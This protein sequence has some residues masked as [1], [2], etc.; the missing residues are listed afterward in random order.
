MDTC[1]QESHSLPDEDINSDLASGPESP[2]LKSD[3]ELPSRERQE[4]RPSRQSVNDTAT[5]LSRGLD[6]IPSSI[7]ATAEQFT[8]GDINN[9]SDYDYDSDSSAADALA[10]VTAAA[11][12][13]DLSLG[14]A[15]IVDP[16]NSAAPTT[17]PPASQEKPTSHRVMVNRIFDTIRSN[18]PEESRAPLTL[19]KLEK[20]IARLHTDKSAALHVPLPAP[21]SAR[22]ERTAAYKQVTKSIS[23]KWNDTVLQNRRA[24][25]LIFPLNEKQKIVR[26]TNDLA[27]RPAS[28]N[29]VAEDH[30]REIADI[31]KDAGV[32]RD[33]DVLHSE[34]GAVDNA[35]ESG[36]LSKEDV[37]R[38]QR[39]LARVRSLV[40][41]Y[42][43]KM[44]RIKRIK[45]KKFRKHLKKDRERL[46]DES[47]A[48]SDGADQEEA[49]AAERRRVEERVTL[50]HKNTSKWVRRQLR[51][52]EGMRDES[53]KAAIEDQL[54][55]HHELKRRQLREVGNR[56]SDS[57]KDQ[58]SDPD[59]EAVSDEEEISRLEK[60]LKDNGTDSRGAPKKGIMS[61]RFMQAAEERK[62][63][64]AL[65]L[66]EELKDDESNDDDLN[67][68][69]VKGRHAFSGKKKR[70]RIE[71][72]VGKVSDGNNFDI[73]NISRDEAVG[74]DENNEAELLE[75]RI[76][77]EY[78]DAV[79]AGLVG[80]NVTEKVDTETATEV[81]RSSA[82]ITPA[83]TTRLGNRLTADSD[84]PWLN[85]TGAKK[86]GDSSCSKLQFLTE[87]KSAVLTS[88]ESKSQTG[89]YSQHELRPHSEELNLASH[90]PKRVKTDDNG[91][92]PSQKGILDVSLV[93]V[94]P[95]RKP[96]SPGECRGNSDKHR[97]S[98]ELKDITKTISEKSTGKEHSKQKENYNSGSVLVLNESTALAKRGSD[99][100]DSQSGLAGEGIRYENENGDLHGENSA[101]SNGPISKRRKIT[102]EGESKQLSHLK[103][104]NSEVIN[105]E[106]LVSSFVNPVSD[107]E[108]KQVPSGEA[109]TVMRKL[110]VNDVKNGGQLPTNTE[111]SDLA[112]MEDIARAF[113]GAGG[114]DLADFE[115][116]KAA[117][118]EKDLPTAKS[119]NAEVLPGWGSWNGA[120]VDR[121]NSNKKESSFARAA[122]ERLEAA[123]S[124]AIKSRS[125]RRMRNV[126]L[127]Q[128]RYQAA[129][130][131]T[132]ASVPY[133]YQS[134]AQWERELSR[135]LCRELVSNSALHNVG[136][137]KAHIKLG[138]A[139]EPLQNPT[140]APR[141][142]KAD[143]LFKRRGKKGIID[144]RKSKAKHRSK[145]RRGFMS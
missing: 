140:V 21:V 125:D 15:R 127:E 60:E 42:D 52:G 100:P 104:T 77:E 57:E 49:M 22:L 94:S 66:L 109:S 92:G 113:A 50:R 45:S 117:E 116:V 17:V 102:R 81:I 79:Q 28:Q 25:H 43:Q 14:T 135:P 34:K 53:T 120:G 107:L 71:E 133:P 144:L 29:D 56:G 58:M 47:G 83:F 103:K 31:L 95:V 145:T 70:L 38:R 24:E 78:D 82:I 69:R 118:V 26:S 121:K 75:R 2:V 93:E 5:V 90:E 106:K 137:G 131:L 76:K 108:R 37:L 6:L 85:G 1:F 3:E 16:C 114:A 11:T 96:I 39:E 67:D 64:E 18:L 105:D 129:T 54:R 72:Q 41:H 36:K 143:E 59:G 13:R 99:I 112:H 33:S 55:L 130:K 35:L 12:R 111:A 142:A 44:K 7:S 91:D 62:R 132:M 138:T 124:N 10:N 48:L 139:L 32:T 8:N 101:P 84:N 110:K 123:R 30:E 46:A 128:S 20:K 63:K 19:P 65:A 134:R 86:H 61:L 23:T 68:K 27:L 98:L 141:V 73:E 4:A 87:G 115:A 89:S 74:D 119:I 88:V 9:D 51:R 40:F 136:K 97:T 126:I 122:R 80:D